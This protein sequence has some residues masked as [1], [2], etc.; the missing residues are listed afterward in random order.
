MT[1]KEVAEVLGISD[2]TVGNQWAT[3]RLWLRKYLSEN[4]T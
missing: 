1:V 2:R 4:P 3:V